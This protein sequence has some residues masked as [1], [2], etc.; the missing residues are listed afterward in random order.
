MLCLWSGLKGVYR[1]RLPAPRRR[2]VAEDRKMQ[3]FVCRRHDAASDMP[4]LEQTGALHVCGLKAGRAVRL[5]LKLQSGQAR[6]CAQPGSSEHAS[7]AG[8]R[9]RVCIAK[10]A[11]PIFA[12]KPETNG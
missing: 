11:W 3:R 5:N 10:T 9:R 12:W 1:G 6:L 2:T 7:E 4:A 8:R